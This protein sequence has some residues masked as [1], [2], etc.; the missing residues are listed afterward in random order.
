MGGIE[1]ISTTCGCLM[2]FGIGTLTLKWNFRKE[3]VL[4]LKTGSVFI[5]KDLLSPAYPRGSLQG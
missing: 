3:I 1:N 5:S 2:P 4:T